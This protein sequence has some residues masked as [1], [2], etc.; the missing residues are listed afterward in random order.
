MSHPIMKLS[1]FTILMISI[2]IAL[3]AI[4]P[5]IVHGKMFPGQENPQFL[6]DIFAIGKFVAGA[7]MIFGL[8]KMA[9]DVMEK[10]RKE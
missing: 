6:L 7:G 9:Y 5:L 3:L 8:G 1:G 10:S 2:G 4:L